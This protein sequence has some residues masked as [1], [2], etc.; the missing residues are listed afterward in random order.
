MWLCQDVEEKGGKSFAPEKKQALE[1]VCFFILKLWFIKLEEM[2]ARIEDIKT[3]SSFSFYW[4][5]AISH[6]KMCRICS[7]VDEVAKRTQQKSQM[8]KRSL[9]FWKAMKL[10]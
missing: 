8:V 6:R 1:I 3:L 2:E 5:D 9:S 7:K 4:L 10:N